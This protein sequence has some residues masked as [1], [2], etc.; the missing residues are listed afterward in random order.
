LRYLSTRGISPPVSLEEALFAGPAPD[1]GL[2]VP[3]RL[4]AVE[5]PREG[6]D[7]ADTAHRVAAAFFA[8]DLSS[9]AL[10]DVVRESLTFGIPLVPVEPG[11]YS[12][13][14]FHGPTLAFK[15]VGARFMAR[16]M[17]HCLARRG[18]EVTVLVATSGDTGSAVASAFHGISGIEVV[19]LFPRGKVSLLQQKLFTTLGAN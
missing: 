1:G 16:L 7:F 5:P 14:L 17:L 15:D 12:L 18:R 11:V 10:E 9:E 4:P 19:V 8:E 2:Y 6:A 3:E 13:E